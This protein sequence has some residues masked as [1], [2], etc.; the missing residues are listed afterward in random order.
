MKKGFTLIELL[1][2]IAIIGILSSVVLASLNSARAKGRDA[3]RISDLKQLQLALELYY[4]SNSQY[5]TALSALTAGNYIATIPTD[6][7][8]GAAYSYAA[9]DTDAALATCESYHIGATLEDAGNNALDSD[10]DAAAGTVCTG[11]G[12]D[13]SSTSAD[14]VYDIKP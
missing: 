7:V 1:V 8:S 5:P 11:G 14:A 10:S 3:R 6:P 13:F 12:T 4:D 2:V 9:L